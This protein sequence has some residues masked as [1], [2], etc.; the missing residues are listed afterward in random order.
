M[1]YRKINAINQSSLKEILK[2]PRAYVN[3]INKTEE[4][5]EEHFRLGALLDDMLLE[6]PERVE[7][8]YCKMSEGSA[9]D[10]IKQIINYVYDYAL[11]TVGSSDIE[12]VILDQLHPEIVKGCRIYG[13]NP[14]WG[15]EALVKNVKNGG[16]VEYFNALKESNGR[17]IISEIDYAKAITAKMSLLGDSYTSYF[18]ST[19][20]QTI[21]KKKI[22]SFKYRGY[23]CKGEVDQITINH[24]QKAIH[25]LDIKSIGSP[26]EFFPINF[27]KFRYDF[28]GAFYNIGLKSDPELVELIAQGY[29]LKP[30]K[31]LVVDI[32]NVSPPLVYVM[33]SDIE[34]VGINGG[35]LSSGRFIEGVE[36]A[37]DRLEYHLNEGDFTYP[38]EYSKGPLIL[39]M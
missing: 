5:E 13:W 27:W 38:M 23:D 35:T 19:K 24:E 22:L 7:E 4:S 25:P 28:Q 36:H 18:F 31:F 29:T 32:N 12:S 11:E 3:A 14:K 15:E 9:S 17:T 33:N 21:I 26:T 6:S 37:F 20:K 10:A 34:N 1:E 39:K 8:K 30:F 2:S 16:G